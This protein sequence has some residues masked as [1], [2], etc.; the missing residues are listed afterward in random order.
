MSYERATNLHGR[1]RGLAALASGL[2][3]CPTART[4]LVFPICF[5]RKD[6]GAWIDSGGIE[7]VGN[8][9]GGAESS[10]RPIRWVEGRTV[11]PVMNDD[12]S[13][14]ECRSEEK[15]ANPA[16]VYQADN[17][18]FF[19][20]HVAASIGALDIISIILETCPSS[21]GLCTAQGRTFLHVAV[22]NRRLNVVSF[23]CQ[24]PSLDWILNM[25]DH[26]GSTALHLAVQ[27]GKL[28]IFCSLYGNKKVHLNLEN[29]S[30]HTPNDIA[31]GMLPHGLNYKSNTDDWIYRA[32][33]Y[34]GANY[35]CRRVDKFER[36]NPNS[37][38]LQPDD[39]TKEAENMKDASQTLGIGSVLVTTVAFGATFALPGGYIADDHMNRGTPTR[40]GRYSF[41]AFMMANTLAFICSSVATTGLMFSGTS[42]VNLKSRQINLAVSVLLMSSSLTSLAAAFA[43]GVYIVLAPVSL[44]TAIV[45]CVLSP[46]VV[47]YKLFE[48]FVM[49]G[50]LARPL[51]LRVGLSR[52][53]KG[54]AKVIVQIMFIE[55]WPFIIIFGWAA[56]A[57]SHRNH[58]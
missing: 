20:V 53:L 9:G 18:G 13:G 42:M 31:R 39:V 22:E 2:H 48:F 19:P 5:R 25:R 7:P 45:V 46:L 11:P 23:V 27:A 30:K 15:R 44:G 50:I 28:R 34:A 37:F 52:G 56:I 38:E 14:W 58:L 8:S 3:R 4:T 29:N 41:D 24:T 57:R 47:L 12:E 54:L 33:T 51:C 36:V 43:L 35:S 1:R 6:D 32:L 49:L 26:D 40:A 10:C 21:A 17:K 16:P 55:L